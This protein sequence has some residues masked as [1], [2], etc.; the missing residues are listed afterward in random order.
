M[1]VHEA[2]LH[3][4]AFPTSQHDSWMSLPH[5]QT[6]ERAQ[7]AP[8]S[9]ALAKERTKFCSGEFMMEHSKQ[10]TKA[11]TG[12]FSIRETDVFTLPSDSLWQQF[13][14]SRRSRTE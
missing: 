10:K 13:S 5:N 3:L 9:V 14:E 1:G 7:D 11:V 2:E 6:G 4:K 8:A 12:R